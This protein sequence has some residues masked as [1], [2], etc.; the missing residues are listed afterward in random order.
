MWI[1]RSAMLFPVLVAVALSAGCILTA[2]IPIRRWRSAAVQG[3]A[4]D[5]GRRSA[6]ARRCVVFVLLN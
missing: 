5:Q 6:E 2:D 4:D 1:W 3:R